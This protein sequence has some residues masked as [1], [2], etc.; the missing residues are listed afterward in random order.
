[1]RDV[2]VPDE[3][4]AVAGGVGEYAILQE[5]IHAQASFGDLEEIALLAAPNRHHRS[6]LILR[7]L[8]QAAE[9]CLLDDLVEDELSI[10]SPKGQL[11]VNFAVLGVPPEAD[12]G[13]PQ[14]GDRH[15]P[16]DGFI[17][18]DVGGDEKGGQRQ[19]RF[20]YDFGLDVAREGEHLPGVDRDERV[21]PEAEL[22]DVVDRLREVGVPKEFVARVALRVRVLDAEVVVSRARAFDQRNRP[23]PE[24]S[25]KKKKKSR[26]ERQTH[27]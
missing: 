15:K 9:A 17:S 25:Q 26:D 18:E 22:A 13:F 1:M 2:Q 21:A 14:G 12:I 7:K 16:G 8:L 3:V 27:L 24:A 11:A 5:S 23:A 20:G 19:V 10:G 6:V 4:F